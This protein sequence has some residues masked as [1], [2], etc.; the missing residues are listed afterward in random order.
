MNQ[1]H[2]NAGVEIVALATAYLIRIYRI[3]DVVN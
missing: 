3:A 1:R 2:K